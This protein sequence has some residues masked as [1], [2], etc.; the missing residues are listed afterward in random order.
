M[1]KLIVRSLGAGTMLALV[2]AAS[3][4]RAQVLDEYS[5][6]VSP[7]SSAIVDSLGA[8]ATADALVPQYTTADQAQYGALTGI[9]LILN[10][11]A[12]YANLM[13]QNT[14]GSTAGPTLQLGTMATGTLPGS[15]TISATA[16]GPQISSGSPGAGY[17]TSLYSGSGS[18]STSIAISSSLWSA[19]EGNGNTSIPVQF[20]LVPGSTYSAVYG[21]T[22]LGAGTPTSTAGATF[23]IEYEYSA[24]PE[25]STIGLIAGLGC[26]V[27]LFRRARN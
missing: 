25:A 12:T 24:V 22:M 2:L 15:G 9:E 23:H 6:T 26:L 17:W 16:L 3:Q 5:Q 21:S 10:S 7:S 8:S 1:N 13:L 20:T 11:T 27:A 19:F 18:G 14:S 4:S